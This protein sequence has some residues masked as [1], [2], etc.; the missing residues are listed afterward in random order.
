MKLKIHVERAS[1]AE[2]MRG[3]EAALKVFEDAGISPW[4]AAQADFDF[5][6]WDLRGFPEPP[7]TPRQFELMRLWGAA[8]EAAVAACCSGWDAE[9]VP[10]SADL[11]IVGARRG[12]EEPCAISTA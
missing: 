8:D 11:A 1:E 2:L 6:T 3:A 10:D 9:Q 7:P 5:E 4:D 12:R